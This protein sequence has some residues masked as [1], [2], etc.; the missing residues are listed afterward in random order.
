[1]R[2]IILTGRTIDQGCGKEI[3]KTSKEYMEN[4]AICEMNEEDMKKL[5]IQDGDRV[6]VTTEFGSVVLTAKKSRR[7]RSSGTVFIPYGAWAN[8]ITGPHTDG[9]GMPLLKGLPAHVEPTE[10]KVLP[11]RDLITKTLFNNEM[12]QGGG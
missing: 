4:V 8:C 7:I 5:G 1:L 10:E 12:L 9:T 3:G 11:I 2:I 6:K